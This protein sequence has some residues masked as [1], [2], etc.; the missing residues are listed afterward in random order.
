[1]TILFV[2]T[3]T[4]KFREAQEILKP[5]KIQLEHV[6]Q[7]YPEIRAEE[8]E[9]VAFE[10]AQSLFKKIK[11]PLIVEDSGLFILSLNGFP[12]TYS[13]WVQKKIGNKGILKLMQGEKRREAYFKSSVAY[14]DANIVKTFSAK[15][16]GTISE[17]ESGEKGFG[18][19]PIF[20]PK[21]EKLTFAE[22]EMIKNRLS[23]RFNA[24]TVFAKWYSTYT[25]E[26][27]K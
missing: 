22:N 21:G 3:N 25:V 6:A 5:Y 1:M 18:Y 8:V 17:K 14:A 9:E 2:T 19:D 23:H 13:A 15:V 20:I 4:H 27:R 12:A 16:D 10:S 11:K 24:F 26:S 7:S